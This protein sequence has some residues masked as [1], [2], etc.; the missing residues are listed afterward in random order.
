MASAAPVGRSVLAGD[1]ISFSRGQ[2]I[3]TAA[4]AASATALLP[5]EK[6]AE[7]DAIRAFP[8]ISK[9]SNTRVPRSKAAKAWSG[10]R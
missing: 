4:P 10:R 1:V 8:E 3:G 5:P 2:H 9:L 7:E 6:E